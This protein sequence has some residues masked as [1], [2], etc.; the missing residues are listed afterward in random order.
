MIT[1]ATALIVPSLLLIVLD[2][3]LLIDSEYRR[4]KAKLVVK[5]IVQ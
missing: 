3:L 1:A 2:G 4:I 5:M